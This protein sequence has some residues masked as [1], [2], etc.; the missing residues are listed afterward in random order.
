MGINMSRIKEYAA[1]L[2][3]HTTAAIKHTAL[4]LAGT[5]PDNVEATK[6]LEATL[7]MLQD[8]LTDVE[9]KDFMFDVDQIMEKYHHQW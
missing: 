2:E 6:A 7:E 8:R 1:R 9:Y 4:I 3:E 5:H